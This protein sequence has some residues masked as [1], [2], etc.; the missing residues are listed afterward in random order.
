M[1][2]AA[3]V[4]VFVAGLGFGYTLKTALIYRMFWEGRRAN[5]TTPPD[6][7]VDQCRTFGPHS[8]LH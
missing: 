7:P 1:L 3:F 5:L 6:C 8:H 4:C 2:T